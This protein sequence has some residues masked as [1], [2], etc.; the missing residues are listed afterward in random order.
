MWSRS[1]E[2][3]LGVPTAEPGQGTAWRLETSFPWPSWVLLLFVLGAIGWVA[4]VYRQEAGHVSRRLRGALVGFRLLTV[5]CL[6]FFLSGAVISLERTS[7]PY[8]AVLVDVSRSMGTPDQYDSEEMRRRVRELLPPSSGEES[9]PSRLNLVKAVLSREEG[10]FLQRLLGSHKLRMYRFADDLQRLGTQDLLNQQDVQ[11]FLPLLRKQPVEGSQ[12][13][14]A[15]AIRQTLNEFRGAPPTAIVVF[16]DG[17]ATE[18]SARLS[19]VADVAR[20]RGVPIITVGVGNESP[21][22][23][24]ALF[25]T[26]VDEVAFVDDPIQFTARIKKSGEISGNV[27]VTLKSGAGGEVL[28][29]RELPLPAGNE[30]A[31]VELN[32]TP[33]NEGEYDFFLEV[34]PVEREFRLDNNREQRHVSVRKEKIR[35]LLIDSSPR[36]EFRYLKHVLERDKTIEVATILQDSDA[37]Y[38]KEDKTAL[39]HFPVRKDELFRYDVI[40]FGDVDL[41]QISSG[42]LE[43]LRVF[44]SE[45]GG[46]VIFVA[47]TKN[48]PLKYQGTAIEP[49]LPFEVESARLPDPQ[50]KLPQSFKPELTSE[51]RHSSSLFRFAENEPESLEIWNQ[52]PGVFWNVQIGKLK[53]GAIPFAE[54]PLGPGGKKFPWIIMQRFGAGKV[55]YH[56]SDETWRW[57]FRVGDLYFGRYWVQAIRYL[58]RSRLL[59]KD[60]QA[61]LVLDRAEYE[62]GEPVQLRVRFL[63]EQLIPSDTGGVTV[64]VEKPG[65]PARTVKLRRL[66]PASSVFEGEVNQL[67]EGS[68]HAWVSAPNFPQAPPARDF[69]VQGASRETQNLRMDGE[70]LRKTAELTGGKTYRLTDVDRLPRELPTGQPV[71]LKS[72]NPIPLWNH[73]LA[74]ALFVMSLTAE[75]ILRKR[76]RLI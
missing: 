50:G 1:W 3:L 29:R 56:A 69:R 25:D 8:L 38:V 30:P 22:R 76:A 60:R 24:L 34:L 44:V 32:Y 72:E 18:E 55:L 9:S 59:G 48:N 26:L 16:S 5:A 28:A 14:P 31:R 52:L 21:L 42:A 43:Q 68:Y 41:D 4:W 62:T 37:D 64:Q 40:I 70:E 65:M 57:R 20:S 36:Y 7:L 61:E 66:S 46:G 75:W 12:T 47:G 49:L 73:W 45:K 53:S 10:E 54:I 33:R 67:T 19:T 27:V 2:K 63:D 15:P 39:P 74:L 71:T 23:D 6:L 13:R 17:I 35:V 51:G 11:A 58:S